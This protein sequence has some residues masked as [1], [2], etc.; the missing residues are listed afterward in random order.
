MRVADGRFLRNANLGSDDAS[1]LL[2]DLVRALGS[3]V[4][5]EYF[6]GLVE[7]GS[8]VATLAGS[9]V[10]RTDFPKDQA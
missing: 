6:H 8:L 10:I 1:V 3:P 4:F 7:S 2:V 5:D 9:R